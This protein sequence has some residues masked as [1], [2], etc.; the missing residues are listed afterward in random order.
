[1]VLQLAAVLLTVLVT[2]LAFLLVAVLAISLIVSVIMS[3]IGGFL[4]QQPAT[5]HGLPP[6][7]T[8]DMMEAFFCRAGRERDSGL[9]RGSTGDCRI[10][11]WVIWARR[12]QWA[13]TLPAGIRV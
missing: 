9:Y 10:R 5:G 4:D 12:R 7:I 2:M 8:E 13:G 6:F 1:M 3:L 11:I